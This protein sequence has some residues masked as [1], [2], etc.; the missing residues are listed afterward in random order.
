MHEEYLGSPQHPWKVAQKWGLSQRRM[1]AL[2][3]LA[4]L[5]VRRAV[6]RAKARGAQR[7][8]LCSEMDGHEFCGW[9]PCP[10]PRCSAGHKG[11][12]DAEW[13][14]TSCQSRG[15]CACRDAALRSRY[16]WDE[17]HERWRLGRDSRN[18]VVARMQA[19]AAA[20]ANSPGAPPAV[21]GL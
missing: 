5:A 19:R 14:C 11:A 20:C 4:G 15:R 7:K 1:Y 9:C 21:E 13:H 12:K 10:I 8:E 6:W 3:D 18:A 17:A 16:G 2:F